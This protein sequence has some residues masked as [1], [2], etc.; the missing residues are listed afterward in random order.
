[1]TTGPETREP[2][3]SSDIAGDVDCLARGRAPFDPL[4]APGGAATGTEVGADAAARLDVRVTVRVPAGEAARWRE[5]KGRT[6]SISGGVVFDDGGGVVPG[7]SRVTVDLT[8]LQ[9]DNAM[10]D[11]PTTAPPSAASS[12]DW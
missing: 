11:P 2:E 12:P 7:Q 8:G 5:Q 1:M 10:R 4:A 6:M 9:S 3:Y